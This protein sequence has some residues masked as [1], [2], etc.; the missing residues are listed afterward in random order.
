MSEQRS[1]EM[2]AG[3]Y[4][5]RD[6]AGVVTNDVHTLQPSQTPGI[7]VRVTD[8]SGEPEF[9]PGDRV[10]DYNGHKFEVAGPPFPFEEE[11]M[12]PVIGEHPSWTHP[13]CMHAR[14]LTKLPRKKSVTIEGP[15]DT[16]QW[17]VSQARSKG[18]LCIEHNEGFGDE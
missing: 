1:R 17:V 4:L 18:G 15:E 2:W 16:V 11:W 13:T 5:W 9:K 6:G 10:R 8:I 7:P 12:V 3:Q 14:F